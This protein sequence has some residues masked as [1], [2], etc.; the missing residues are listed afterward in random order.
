M[1]MDLK[2]TAGKY[3][4]LVPKDMGALS[5]IRGKGMVFHAES[6]EAEGAGSMCLLHMEGMAGLMR[7]ESAAF[8]PSR[9]DGPILSTDRIC[10]D[11]EETLLLELIDTTL[12]ERRFPELEEVKNRYAGLPVFEPKKA[13]YS[14]LHLPGSAFYRGREIGKELDR[15]FREYSEAY[16]A[17]LLRCPACDPAEKNRKNAVLPDGLLSKGGP[18]VD[19]FKSLIGEEKTA[20]FMKKYMFCCEQ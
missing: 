14:D 20:E 17:A 15:L 13:W 6:Y 9:L 7:M 12:S 10:A 3:F 1:D 8:T 4:R 5:Q 2:A 16:F 19:Q 11:G 18:A